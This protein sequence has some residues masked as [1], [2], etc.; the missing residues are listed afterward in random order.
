LIQNKEFIQEF[1]DE[2]KTHV[3]KV[4]ALLIKSSELG[5]ADNVNTVFR[6]VHSI[7]GTAGFFG[8][9]NVVSLAHTMENI[10]GEVRAGKMNLGEDDIDL[11][12]GANDLMKEMIENVYASEEFDLS[13]ILQKLEQIL[14]KYSATEQKGEDKKGITI[15]TQ[16][17]KMIN[18][19]NSNLELIKE[20]LVHG[21]HLYEI[22]FR[23]N[24]DL[25]N[26]REG[27][28]KLFKKIQAVGMLVDTLTDH[29]EINSL[30]DV[31]AALENEVHDVYLGIWVTSI[32]EPE[33]LAEAID[34]SVNNI[35]EIE[36]LEDHLEAKTQPKEENKAEKEV[37]KT[38][39]AEKAE[40]NKKTED[41][42]KLIPEVQQ[43]PEEK[44]QVNNE[45]SNAKSVR[46]ERDIKDKLEKSEEL[47]K[48]NQ[49][50]TMDDSVRVNVVLLNDLMNMASEMVLGRNQL[51]RTLEDYRKTIPGLSAILQNI[52]LLTSGIQGKIMQTRMQPLS[53]VFGKFPR[54]IRDMSKSLSKDMELEIDGEGVEL[55][56]SI[57]E[58]LKDPLTH[59]VRNS[60]DHG[61]ELPE[62][63]E[64]QGKPR[65]GKIKLHAYQEGG[66][67]NIDVVDDGKGMSVE[68]L[69]QKA[70]EKNIVSKS[71]I[72][73][74]NEMEIL[75]LIFKPGFSTA[76][77]VTDISGRGVGMDVVRTNIE[78]LGGAIEIYTTENVGTT[79]RLMLPLTLAII[80][81]LIVKT[82]NLKFA[83][84]QANVKEIVRIKE[85]DTSS[86]IEFVNDAE[87]LRLRGKLLPIV[88]LSEVLGLPRK[89][90]EKNAQV[91]QVT[92]I[93][94]L[95][96]GAR[97]FGLA[98]D[99]VLGSEE[100]LVKPN[101]SYLKECICYSGVTIMGDGKIAM[102]LDAEG[103]IK[104]KDLKFPD[105]NAKNVEQEHL[106]S[107]MVEAQNVVLFKC[108]GTE[109][110]ALDMSMI[111]RIIEIHKADIE[112][113][114]GQFY[115]QY[116]GKSLRVIQ[117]EL[118][119]MKKTDNEI[120]EK[121]YVI[122][123]KLV[124]HPI[125]LIADKILDNINVNLKLSTDE[126]EAE[127]LVGTAI[128]NK[129]T[130][131]FLNLYQLFEKA[132]AKN[133]PT[134]SIV[135]EQKKR[136]LLVE[137]TPF[138]QRMSTSYLEAAGYEVDL[139]M[140]GKEAWELLEDKEYSAVI[141]DIQMP[142]M[143]GYEL[144][145]RIKESKRLNKLPVIAMTSMTGEFN[146][147]NGLKKGF[148]FYE[149][150]LDR[151]SL[152]QTVEHAILG[153]TGGELIVKGS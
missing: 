16:N 53:N 69:K 40:G 13:E 139:A 104:I 137:D 49:A 2:A 68:R 34:I 128:H 19:N 10:F 133:Y 94:V 1:V 36:V 20:G 112:E 102:I 66:Y 131:L 151:D 55:D 123:P 7:K 38:T 106:L 60:A 87:V 54:I 142:V 65:I 30:D 107:T 108:A 80:Q 15:K 138:F 93:L 21:H 23:I 81:A 4:E 6:A 83:I 48:E 5:K 11:L 50:N 24:Q 3:E 18:L 70:I 126:V 44:P 77:K 61:I 45:Q 26:Y 27:P 82:E 39:K 84:P 130:L 115:I 148:D 22:K 35:V 103:I 51:L 132:D 127:C 105:E 143:D 59:L 141:S 57:I 33:M 119:V 89:D 78:R 88:Y 73:L 121:Q 136:L 129:K 153:K 113:I 144:V 125:G 118:Y 124:R 90:K 29:S 145:H 147:E 152:L 64:K 71:E 120:K 43:L 111:A 134:A 100:I 114:G 85:G 75:R 109:T 101:P 25:L 52:D 56:K 28:M 110:F 122:I 146:K 99:F 8:L 14:E 32:L 37:K 9:K 76:E 86:S 62:E 149:Y 72:E 63:R 97:S 117:P 140:N 96:I 41:I 74:M 92:R 67:V 135:I 17:K 98:V 58:G 116:N 95:K 42:D 12:L 46:P 150:K 31:L 79:I 91:N 47:V